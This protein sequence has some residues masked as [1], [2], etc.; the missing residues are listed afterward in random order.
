MGAGGP[1]IMG[2]LGPGGKRLIGDT[3]CGGGG[4]LTGGGGFVTMLRLFDLHIQEYENETDV[5]L[6]P[7]IA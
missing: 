3:P 2:L 4:R 5:V 7:C 6:S 1:F